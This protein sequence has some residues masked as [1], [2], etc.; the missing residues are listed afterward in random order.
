MGTRDGAARRS[1]HLLDDKFVAAVDTFDRLLNDGD[2]RLD[3]AIRA[4]NAAASLEAMEEDEA[5]D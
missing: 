5:E 1:R 4:M 3:A 2:E